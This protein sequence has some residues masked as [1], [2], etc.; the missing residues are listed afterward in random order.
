MRIIK[1]SLCKCPSDQRF[2]ANGAAQ[3]PEPV[4]EDAVTLL[5]YDGHFYGVALTVTAPKPFRSLCTEQTKRRSLAP[6]VVISLPATLAM[7]ACLAGMEV[8]D[9]F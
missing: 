1:T 8:T 5:A 7:I 4:A 3:G 6:L 2:D 9:F